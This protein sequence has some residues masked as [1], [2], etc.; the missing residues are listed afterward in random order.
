MI[1]E[2]QIS[3]YFWNIVHGRANYLHNILQLQMQRRILVYAD[4]VEHRRWSFLV[5]I[6]NA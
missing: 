3:N 6:F 4:P 2:L 5:K 1:K